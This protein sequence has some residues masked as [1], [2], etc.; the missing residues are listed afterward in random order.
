MRLHTTTWIS[1]GQIARE[2]GTSHAKARKQVAKVE[3]FLPPSRGKYDARILDLL[4]AMRD[5]QHRTLEEPSNDWLT[6]Y[7][8][9]NP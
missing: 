4:R 3:R 7:L 2:L 8:K 6:S 9:G 1:I 5:E